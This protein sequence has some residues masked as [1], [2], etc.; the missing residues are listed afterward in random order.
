MSI[1]V[2]F[3]DIRIL[4]KC[5]KR[6]K[7]R[8]F[9]PN[10]VIVPYESPPVNE[11]RQ[12]GIIT[13]MKSE[14][15]A[16]RTMKISAKARYALRIVLD[17]AANTANGALRR[18]QEIARAQNISEKFLS[19]L[20]IPLRQKGILS[21]VR[22]A[23]GGFCLACKP[24]KIRLLDI[25]QSVQGAFAILDCLKPG[26]KC[27][28]ECSCLVKKVWGEINHAFMKTLSKHTVASILRQKRAAL[29]IIGC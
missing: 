2:D 8:L 28:K 9:Q 6:L 12:F 13:A 24:E 21:S 3:S 5:N 27:P 4:L 7:F 15:C 11:V 29:D 1:T 19:R 22:G 14:E 26:V 20:V 18:G 25:I 10:F 17:V 23:A 16:D